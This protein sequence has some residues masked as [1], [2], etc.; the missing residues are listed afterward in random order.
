MADYQLPAGSKYAGSTGVDQVQFFRSG[1]TAALP[2][3]AIFK[4]RP[5]NGK[6]TSEYNVMLVHAVADAE[7]VVR[8]ALVELSVRNVAAQDAATIK[9]LLGTLGTMCSNADFQDDAVVELLLP[10]PNAITP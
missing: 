10:A 2:R 7:G 9:T 6:P 3:L 8:N 4:R 1:H 5:A